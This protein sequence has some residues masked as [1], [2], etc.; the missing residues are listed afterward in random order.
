MSTNEGANKSLARIFKGR[1]ERTG[2]P[3]NQ[4]ALPWLPPYRRVIRFQGRK[5]MLKRKENSSPGT[6]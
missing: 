1:R 2:Q 4:A 6:R 5:C 3:K